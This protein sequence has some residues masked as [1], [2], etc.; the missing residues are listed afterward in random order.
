LDVFPKYLEKH[1]SQKALFYFLQFNILL[2]VQA[3]NQSVLYIQMELCG[4]TLRQ[5]MDRRP[6]DILTGSLISSLRLK[7][8]LTFFWQL[9]A[10]LQYLHDKKIIHHDVKVN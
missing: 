10:A 9:A 4:L 3:L 7:T 5:W 6:N 2:S 1:P 8:G